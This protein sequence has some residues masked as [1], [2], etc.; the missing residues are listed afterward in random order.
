LTAQNSGRFSWVYGLHASMN[1]LFRTEAKSI[2]DGNDKRPRLR[3]THG[4]WERED[5]V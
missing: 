5:G 4:K 1:A 3:R 2:L